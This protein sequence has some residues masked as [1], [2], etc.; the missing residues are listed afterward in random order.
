MAGLKDT[1]AEARSAIDATPAPLLIQPAP[2]FPQGIA[3]R[4]AKRVGRGQIPRTSAERID[5][6]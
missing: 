5:P 4:P 3:R 6:L 2:D 1:V